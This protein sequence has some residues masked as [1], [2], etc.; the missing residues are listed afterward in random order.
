MLK[1]ILCRE[2]Y[3]K[4]KKNLQIREKTCHVY[5]ILKHHSFHRYLMQETF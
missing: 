4:Y 1:C 3:F 5:F 2:M